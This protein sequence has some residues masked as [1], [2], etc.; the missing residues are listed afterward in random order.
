MEDAIQK[1]K[2]RVAIYARV[3][4]PERKRKKPESERKSKTPEQDPENQLA[5]LREFCRASGWEIVREYVDRQSAKPGSDRQQLKQLFAEAPKRHFDQVLFWALDRFSREGVYRTLHDLR[6]L[7]EWGINWR[8]FQEA[9]FDS[10]GPFK[11]AVIAIMASLAKV[12]RERI[13]ERT[14]AGL[15]RARKQGVKLGRPFVDRDPAELRRLRMQGMSLRAISLKT[16]LTLTTVA[17]TLK[18]KT[19]A[20]ASLSK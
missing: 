15:E 10:C 12:E 9:Y 11:D 20:A 6:L 16:G 7:S 3:S 1:K 19:R 13:S 17:R 4:L 18:P 8:S 5:Q 14:R 2:L